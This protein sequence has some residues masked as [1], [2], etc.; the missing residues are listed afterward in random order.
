M[1]RIAIVNDQRLAVEALRRVVRKVPSYDVAWIAYDGAEA[2]TKAAGDPPDLILMDLLMPVMDGV[3]ATRR[4]MAGS[5]CAIVVVTAT[6]TGNAQL[7]FQAMGHGALDAACTPILGMN[8]EAEGG[9]PLLEKIRNVARLIGKSSGPATHRTETW[10]QPRSRPAIVGIGA[11]TGGP[12]ALAEILGAL[13]GDFPVPIVAV[14]HVDAQ[15][16]PGLA[17]WLDGLV[18][19]DVAVAVEGDRP[20][21]GKVLVSGTND[22]LELGADGRLHYTPNPIETPYRPSVDVLFESLARRPTTTGVAVL[23]TGMG[24][25]GATGLLSLRNRGWH[26]IAQDKATCVVYGM[27]KAAAEIGAAVEILPLGRIAP[28]LQA[29]VN[30]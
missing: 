21:A 20:T 23:L 11:S 5:P 26:T 19:L 10:T 14:Q 16:A 25:D 7:V 18:A 3:E 8:G 28:A 4:I 27:P 17:S 2:V 22:H 6:V 29:F 15:F 12:K 9:A 24:K 1:L 13:P 30:A